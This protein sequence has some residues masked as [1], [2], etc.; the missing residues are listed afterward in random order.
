MKFI[1]ILGNRCRP[2]D[3]GVDPKNVQLS[4]IRFSDLFTKHQNSVK[5]TAS[6]K[7]S[8]GLSVH[9]YCHK[10]KAIATLG[11]KRKADPVFIG[12]PL[13]FDNLSNKINS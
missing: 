10:F 7:V 6:G 3:K 9:S 8:G 11:G 1:D 13:T 12:K 5:Y 4:W 2:V